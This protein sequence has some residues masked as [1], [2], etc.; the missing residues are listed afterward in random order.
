MTTS[1][2]FNGKLLAALEWLFTD[3]LVTICEQIV[4]IDRCLKK[5][6]SGYIT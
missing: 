3:E 6:T 2:N 4:A 1:M 5:I